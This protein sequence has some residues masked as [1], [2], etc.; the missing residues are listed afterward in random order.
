MFPDGAGETQPA[1]T[2]ISDGGALRAKTIRFLGLRMHCIAY[3][4]MFA[5][6]DEWIH[7]PEGRGHSVALMNV[8]CCVSGLLDRKLRA[9]YQRA[10]FLA[11]D[12]MAFL[13]FARLLVDR[14]TDSMYGP[15]LIVKVAK[16]APARG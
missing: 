13:R 14:R 6:F 2:D 10:D 15:D 4:A 1:A 9:L 16:E 8:N 3:E 12:S 11:I 7:A 5:K